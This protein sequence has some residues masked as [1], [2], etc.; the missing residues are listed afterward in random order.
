[1]NDPQPEGHM[2]SHVGRRKFLAT[3]GGA[4]VVWPLAARAQQ[5]ERMRRVGVLMNVAAD[6]PTGQTRLLTFAQA[7]A[8][9]GWIDG[10][11]IRIDVRWGPGDPERIRKYAAELVALAPDLILASGGTTLGP[12]REVSRTVPTVFTGVG[13]PVGA[14][15]VDNL[16]RPG[17]NATGFVAFEWSISGKWVDLLKE[18]APGVTR[19]VVLRDSGLASG[20]SQF[21]V[22]QAMAPS[23]RVEIKP[24]NVGGAAEIERAVAA[25]ARAPNGGLIAT[26]GGRVRFH[27]DLIVKLAARHKLPAVY[28]DRVYVASGGLISYGPDFVDQFR[29]AAGYVDRVLK[30]EKPADLPVQQPTKYELVINLK[31][32]KALG[33]EM[34]ASVLARADEVIE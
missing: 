17:G 1:M 20:A 29:H 18:I 10:H 23:L 28:Y 22:I 11:N 19:A 27:R 2:A 25:F 33:L 7:L 32:A 30:G 9:A 15:F 6:D 13:D 21:A 24:V 3:L 12:L 8:Q 4:A 34:P 14:G 26:G 31:T 5:S 16:A